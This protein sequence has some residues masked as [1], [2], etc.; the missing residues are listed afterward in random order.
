M[1]KEI[2]NGCF[3][4]T[5]N[6]K[7]TFTETR[8]KTEYTISR[9]AYSFDIETTI[10]RM[11]EHTFMYVGQIAVNDTCYIFREWDYILNAIE[12]IYTDGKEHNQMNIIWVANL[13]YEMSFMLPR[14]H[15]KFKDYAT[16]DVFA[17]SARHPIYVR[18][19][20][21]ETSET[22]LEF[23]DTLRISGLNLRNTAKNYCTTQKLEMDYS[24]IRNSKTDISD[25]IDYCVNDVFICNEYYDYL[26]DSLVDKGQYLPYT[27]TG[28]VRN[29][30][31]NDY[32]YSEYA[33]TN[34]VKN[35]FPRSLEEYNRVMT[36]LYSGG[37]THAN[38]DFVGDKIGYFE[39]DKIIDGITG[40]D[41]TSSYPAVMVH[42]DKFPLSAFK[43]TR[44]LTTFEQLNRKKAWYCTV[45]LHNVRQT[46]SHSLISAS[47][48]IKAE[49]LIE[50]NGRVMYADS[51]TIMLNNIDYEYISLFYS[52]NKDYRISNAHY[53]DKVG[54]LPDYLLKN[55]LHNGQQKAELKKQ[56]LNETPEYFKNK[57]L[58]NC[59]YGLCVQR[60]V[61]DSITWD[62]ET[63]YVNDGCDDYYKI[64]NQAVLNPFWGIYVTSFARRNL[65]INM[66]NIEKTGASVVYYDTDSLYIKDIENAMDVIK[67]WNEKMYAWNKE[68][69]L[70]ECFADLGAWDID[71]VVIFKTLGAKRYIKM[72][73]HNHVK[74]TIAGLPKKAFP[75]KDETAFDYFTD[76]MEIDALDSMKLTA[77]YKD[78][79]Y[80]DDIT[81]N[82]GNTETMLEYS[83]TSLIEIPFK[84]TLS[85]Q[86]KDLLNKLHKHY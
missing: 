81:D 73:E 53:C 38:H 11:T 46:T 37:I 65:C 42:E 26:L 13:G 2:K 4:A 10:N 31:K 67:A 48:C 80:T 76:N 3:F 35:M 24:E 44:V 62:Y 7:G 79:A 52:W 49:G 50:D 43:R 69:K 66:Y 47:K 17:D 72:D 18:I 16:I 33:E 20:D 41:F 58:F 14:L 32:Q 1:N 84:L 27:Q 63:G 61:R 51:I 68:L 57:A 25:I 8:G 22:Y 82:D 74:C 77:K 86:F 21:S 6:S 39:N 54:R 40:I 78:T 28:I 19:T 5:D 70:H 75:Y 15:I 85:T 55:M 29:L 23:R 36:W 12:T 9:T 45:E 34:A 59:Y 83:G 30:V 60:L 71:P 64:K 56:G